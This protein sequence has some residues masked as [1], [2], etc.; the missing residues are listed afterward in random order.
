[1]FIEYNLEIVCQTLKMLTYKQTNIM[2]IVLPLHFC[3][4]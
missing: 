1:M 3:Y 4:L 2:T